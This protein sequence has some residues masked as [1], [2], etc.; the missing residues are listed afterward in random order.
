LTAYYSSVN[1]TLVAITGGAE[2][3]PPLFCEGDFG[4]RRI[5]MHLAVLAAMTLLMVGFAPAAMADD[6]SR[7]CFPFCND[8]RH[9]DFDHHDLFV[10]DFDEFDDVF[11][12]CEFIGFDGD[13]PVF[14]CEF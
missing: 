14:L 11:D 4:M 6:F 8:F 3:A 9:D 5:K 2:S 10:N 1:V 7:N 12:D 13:D